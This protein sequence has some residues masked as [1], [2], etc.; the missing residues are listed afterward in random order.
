MC[1]LERFSKIQSQLMCGKLERARSLPN[2]LA[3]R[4][5]EI[6]NPKPKIKCFTMNHRLFIHNKNYIIDR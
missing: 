3:C 5:S 2:D 6:S 4:V 1:D